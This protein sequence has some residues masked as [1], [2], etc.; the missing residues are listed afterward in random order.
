MPWEC[1]CTSSLAMQYFN[2][3]RAKALFHPVFITL[4]WCVGI[5]LVTPRNLE[6]T[7]APIADI[8]PTARPPLGTGRGWLSWGSQ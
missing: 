4:F 1:F 6:Q 5:W 2:T 7:Q 3:S 8:V